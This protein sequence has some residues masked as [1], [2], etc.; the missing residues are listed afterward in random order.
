MGLAG[1]VYL[2]LG[3]FT[4]ARLRPFVQFHIFQSIFISIAFV[5]ISMLFEF[6]GDFLSWI[7]FINKIVA[8]ITFLLNMPILIHFSIIQ[9]FVYIFMLY[10]ALTSFAGRYSYVPW[11]SEIIGQNIGR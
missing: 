7:P 1:F 3:L 11:V 10:L 4:N 5:L 6:I 9:L 2:L 8:T